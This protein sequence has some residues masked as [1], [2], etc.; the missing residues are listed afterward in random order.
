[1]S[2]KDFSE[3]VNP[4]MFSKGEKALVVMSGGQDSTTCL[5]VALAR[6]GEGNV[7]AICFNY[8]QKHAVE[9]V[10][11]RIICD[12]HN[13]PLSEVDVPALRLMRSSA[14]VTHED[15]SA[16][17]AYLDKLPAS[18]VPARNALFLTMAWGLA[19]EAGAK[20]IYTGVCQTD[21]SGYPDCRDAF[22]TKL[23]AALAVGYETAIAIHT[24][25][26]F[27]DKADTFELA[28]QTGMLQDVLEFSH[29][30]Y[31]GDHETQHA[32]GFGCGE[33]PACKLRAKGYDEYLKRYKGV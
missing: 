1:M 25:L 18:F 7:S 13:V 17:H 5:G 27:L 28:R 9:L 29:T 10:A 21:Y 3:W 2:K 12:F 32:W 22:I 26:M 14:L 31:E 15:T 24:P 8:G 33:C 30:C 20:H 19:M 11:A 6:H 23:Q 4:D 16:Q